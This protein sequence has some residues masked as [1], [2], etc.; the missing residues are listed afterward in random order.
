MR[1][2]RVAVAMV[3]SRHMKIG[4][5][6]WSFPSQP[7]RPPY[8]PPYEDAIDI[9]GEI[10]FE[11][12]ELILYQEEDLEE[13]WTPS[14][15]DAIR[16]Q[17]DGHG[18]TVPQFAMYQDAVSHIVSLDP[19]ERERALDTFE[20]GCKLAK[21]FGSP[22]VNF[23]G[24]WPI[25]IECPVPYVPAYIHPNVPRATHF[26]PKLRMSMPKPFDWEALWENYV[27]SIK[28]CTEMT[29]AHG[30]KLALE[31]HAH[32]MVPGTD[33]MLRLWDW[34]QD[35]ALGFNLDTA[36]HFIQR[37]YLPWSVY[38]LGDKLL[39]VHVRDG[40]GI[41]TYRLPLGMGVIDWHGLVES[42]RDVGYDGALSLEMY[43]KDSREDPWYY[44]KWSL[45]YLR[46]VLAET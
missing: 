40:D 12:V 14:R 1:Y 3:Y 19:S 43:A 38:K 6:A 11:A 18:L 23:V 35:D 9:I 22:L 34:V 42:L 28:R 36:W 26:E 37:E 45:E 10:G 21:A 16:R 44:S 32:V 15:V 27:D 4:A 5:C 33:A 17:I 31:G 30:Q 29:K 46:R 25:G 20:K 41:L 2:D 7:G 39:H 8:M 13:Y 24:Q